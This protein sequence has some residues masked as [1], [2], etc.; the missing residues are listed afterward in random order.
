MT[1]NS[2]KINTRP[3]LHAHKMF[4]RRLIFSAMKINFTN[5]IRMN[6]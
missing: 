3:T 4:N 1:Y 5:M 6:Y 2:I